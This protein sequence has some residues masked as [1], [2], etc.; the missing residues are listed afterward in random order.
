GTPHGIPDSTSTPTY[1]F[2]SGPQGYAPHAD[3][4]SPGAGG[5]QEHGLPQNGVGDALAGY[6]TA[7]P[8]YPGQGYGGP[9]GPAQP[10][11]SG[12]RD[13]WNTPPAPDVREPWDRGPVG[14][15]GAPPEPN[16]PYYEGG[17]ENGRFL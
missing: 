13:H 2:G 12:Y 1:P 5:Y 6:D 15:Q 4:P 10:Q 16:R 14:Y 17:Y 11:Q 9:Q 3:T 7:P 8:H